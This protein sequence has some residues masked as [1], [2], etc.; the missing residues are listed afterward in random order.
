MC[1]EYKFNLNGQGGRPTL[2]ESAKQVED[3]CLSHDLVNIWR[4]RNP[5]TKCISWCQK[6]PFIQRR[7]DYWLID[8]TLQEEI[9]QVDII[10]SIKSDHSAI[11]L[12][13]NGIDNETW[14]LIL[15]I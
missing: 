9:D 3:I 11:S 6:T 7:L 4:V 2:K 15:E 5:G 1:C 12:T 10:P 14:S 13:I 8:N